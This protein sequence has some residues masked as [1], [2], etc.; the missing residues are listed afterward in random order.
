MFVTI[1]TSIHYK[2]NKNSKLELLD[3]IMYS[4]SQHEI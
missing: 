4:P 1:I 3:E 2:A